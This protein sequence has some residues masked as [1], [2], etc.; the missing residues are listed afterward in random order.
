MQNGRA[1]LA[2]LDLPP[3][4]P[5]FDHPTVESRTV[6]VDGWGRTPSMREIF[7][8]PSDLDWP[9]DASPNDA[10]STTQPAE[11]SAQETPASEKDAT[12]ALEGAERLGSVVGEA[13][14]K[15]LIVRSQLQAPARRRPLPATVEDA[16]SS[17]SGSSPAPSEESPDASNGN[18][19]DLL[20]DPYGIL[21]ASGF[22]IDADGGLTSLEIPMPHGDQLTPTSASNAGGL[23]VSADAFNEVQLHQAKEFGAH[24]NAFNQSGSTGVSAHVAGSAS[25]SSVPAEASEVTQPGTAVVT[26]SSNSNSAN[27]GEVSQIDGNASTSIPASLTPGLDAAFLSS[28]PPELSGIFVSPKKPLPP[29][30]LEFLT[31]PRKSPRSKGK[32]SSPTRNVTG[33]SGSGASPIAG[34]STSMIPS[35]DTGSNSPFDAGMEADFSMLFQNPEI[36][37]MLAEFTSSA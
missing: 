37:A 19:F 24:L 8:T 33:G 11:T 29:Q 9:S 21:A 17:V 32:I 26:M 31:S 28:L 27:G 30:I 2:Q 7:P 23:T 36:Q 5:I 34:S 10:E 15:E 6:E 20:E 12:S 25:A 14:D 3:S 16:S 18:L 35:H 1:K 13:K 22:G 4:S